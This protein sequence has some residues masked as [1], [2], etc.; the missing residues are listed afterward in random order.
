MRRFNR[1]N[2]LQTFVESENLAIMLMVVRKLYPEY[3]GTLSRYANDF[4]DYPLNML[5]CRK[6]LF[7]EYAEW[8]FS[9]LF[10]CEKYVKNSPYTRA[11]R[12]YGYLAEFLMPVFFM[13]HG[14]KMTAVPYHCIGEQGNRGGLSLSQNLGRLVLKR[15]LYAK[16]Q[17]RKVG[18]DYSVAAG[19]Q[20]DGIE[21][22]EK[23][24]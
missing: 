5:I 8:L 12:L 6:E 21:I 16:D 19:L 24:I 4:I 17:K 7:D 10:Q 15:L 18:I 1:W 23:M 9:I 20:G 22:L 13:Y 11:R 3:Y 14:Y 2:F